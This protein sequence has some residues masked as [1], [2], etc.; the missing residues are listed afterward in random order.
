MSDYQHYV[1]YRNAT[2]EIRQRAEQAQRTRLPRR[3][4]R[5]RGRRAALARSLHSIADRLDG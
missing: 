3:R 1:T 5:G 2:D 4:Q